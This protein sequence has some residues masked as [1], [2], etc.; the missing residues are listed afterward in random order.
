[1]KALFISIWRAGG[2]QRTDALGAAVRVLARTFPFGNFGPVGK[3]A[4]VVGAPTPPLF[5]RSGSRGA[6]P[7]APHTGD[8]LLPRFYITTCL[9]M[10]PLRPPE[11][12]NPPE[13]RRVLGVD[14][15]WKVS[16]VTTAPSEHCRGTI[17]QRLCNQ[18][19]GGGL[20][21]EVWDL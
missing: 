6:V 11:G 15:T 13:M 3:D 12:W 19:G 7:T 9:Q 21:S 14:E 4:A 20:P 17:E 10:A 18:R 1:M 16:P 5:S 2:R 8:A